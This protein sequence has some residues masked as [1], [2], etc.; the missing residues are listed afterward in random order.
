MADN[1]PVAL[2]P[3]GGG[4]DISTPLGLALGFG[5]LSEDAI[6]RGIRTVA[7]LLVGKPE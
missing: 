4:L 3:S 7:D 5:A 1:E 6:K 2:P